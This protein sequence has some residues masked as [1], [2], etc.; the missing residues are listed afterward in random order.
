MLRRFF[1]EV[2]GRDVKSLVEDITSGL[3]AAALLHDLYHSS[4]SHV[5]EDV[6]RHLLGR[7]TS[8]LGLCSI[9]RVDKFMLHVAFNLAQEP[10]NPLFSVDLAEL[11]RVVLDLLRRSGV[12]LVGEAVL[13]AA[14]AY[15]SSSR[16]TV[17]VKSFDGVLKGSDLSRYLE[18][19]YEDFV[20]PLIRFVM[21]DCVLDLDRLD[22][23]NR[24]S[25]HVW[26]EVVVNWSR[27]AR[28]LRPSLVE[29]G[30]RKRLVVVV[31]DS[32]VPLIQE[33]FVRRLHQYAEIYESDE[34]RAVREL[35][36]HITCAYLSSSAE[37]DLDVGTKVLRLVATTDEALLVRIADF[38]RERRVE[39]REREG[40]LLRYTEYLL[41]DL[42]VQRL[43][44]CIASLRTNIR[45]DLRRKL[46]VEVELT[47]AMFDFLER[48]GLCSQFLDL[49]DL[50][51]RS[52]RYRCLDFVDVCGLPLVFISLPV[53]E[54]GGGC[55]IV[56]RSSV[57]VR[58][59]GEAIEVVAT[60]PRSLCSYRIYVPW[61]VCRALSSED[62]QE[63]AKYLAERFN[64][65]VKV[66]D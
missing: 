34:S 27:M 10:S 39:V 48:R 11:R 4:W 43:P 21:D 1:E 61:E 29:V 44:C 42:K 15:P 14:L 41:E 51:V 33:L 60:V 54:I 64:D 57:L 47:N 9:E 5:L 6:L 32:Y 2:L 7:V 20:D 26:G 30:G 37:R 50:F 17:F 13:K 36:L 58:A 22:Y 49:Q 3:V 12:S 24:D 25:L 23:L 16:G 52:L 46:E 65:I 63:L 8:F 53:F 56:C 31:P 40:L 66:S 55:E 35:L 38:L 18:L 19:F 62:L 45:L 28:A 59:G